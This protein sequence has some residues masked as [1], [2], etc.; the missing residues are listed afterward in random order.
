MKEII[1]IDGKNYEADTNTM[2]LKLVRTPITSFENG[3]VYSA[4][5]FVG[6]KIVIIQRGWFAGSAKPQY[7]FGGLGGK[8]LNPYSN[9]NRETGGLSTE[10]VLAYL[11]KNECTFFGNV[12]L[13]LTELR[14]K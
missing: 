12:N 3:D 8:I 11:N 7:F 2:Q 5:S 13:F 14:K 6:D 10:E 1:V 4:K 9:S